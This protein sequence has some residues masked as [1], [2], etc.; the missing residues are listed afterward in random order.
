MQVES[1][2]ERLARTE[3]QSSARKK[4]VNR[5]KV[6][7][8]R[9]VASYSTRN[10]RSSRFTNLTS[11]ARQNSSSFF[12]RMAYTDTYASRRMK[13]RSTQSAP[14]T[15]S[16]G[17]S[18]PTR[19]GRTD[20]SF[21]DRMALTETFA[22][23]TM[24]G[25]L[26]RTPKSTPTKKRTTDGFFERM[27]KA[28]TYASA[29]MK[30][31]VQQ[32]PKRATPKS[33]TTNSFFERMATADTFASATM[34]GKIEVTPTNNRNNYSPR[35]STSKKKTTNSFFDNLSRQE[36]R[37]SARRK[38]F[39]IPGFSPHQ[40]MPPR[41][42]SSHSHKKP[43]PRPSSLSRPRSNSTRYP[44]SGRSARSVYSDYTPRSTS[45]TRSTAS[46]SQSTRS[47]PQRSINTRST[48]QTRRSDIR[49]TSASRTRTSPSTFTSSRPTT[50][51]ATATITPRQRSSISPKNLNYNSMPSPPTP[52][53]SFRRRPSTASTASSVN[54]P[55]PR[56]APPVRAPPP[57]REALK[58]ESDDDMSF[59]DDS[60]DSLDQIITK[61]TEEGDMGI[62][63][64]DNDE[65]PLLPETNQSSTADLLNLEGTAAGEEATNQLEAESEAV[66]D[67]LGLDSTD[68]AETENDVVEDK[69]DD[70]PVSQLDPFDDNNVVAPVPQSQLDPFDDPATPSISKSMDTATDETMEDTTG[71]SAEESN[72]HTS[73]TTT[74]T[75]DI[76]LA[77]L[78][79]EKYD[80]SSGFQ[81]LDPTS[82]ALTEALLEFQSGQLSNDDFSVLFIEA[83]FER[84]FE[85]G[86][87]WEVD[88]G[89][90]RELEEDEGGG[91]DLDGRAFV[92]KQ[93]ARL[94]TKNNY[95]VAAA[96]GQVIVDLEKD[97]VR[98]ENYSYYVAG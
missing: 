11:P 94:D 21:F 18:S 50:S 90:A 73:T 83:L 10:S 68:A 40:S 89:T 42:S 47:S 81:T 64:D 19:S 25:K 66:Q 70:P 28:D 41:P 56:A 24:K 71:T 76:R 45:R 60:E 48:S 82:L 43:S 35:R 34:K 26:T 15:P 27:A 88:P 39:D 65:T 79:S 55:Q 92:V 72:G 85:N 20:P 67:L 37:S 49:P 74:N 38:E 57:K 17:S 36:T 87:D 78:C 3:T 7:S 53:S 96:K 52:S 95:S 30:G 23:A 58:F 16:R 63:S 77:L 80:P 2:F 1:I 54:K 59:G 93:Q 84:D 46:M 98:M 12:E 14:S 32:S 22:S 51:T 33:R 29:T 6:L 13:D 75:E 69:K 86:E 31:K 8:S 9:S 61:D 62:D 4:A 44:S 5:A 97:E 91:G